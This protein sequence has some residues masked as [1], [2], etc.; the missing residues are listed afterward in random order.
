MEDFNHH[1]TPPFPQAPEVG[2]H[3]ALRS[4]PV[5]P[6][7]L[8]ENLQYALPLQAGSMAGYR[9]GMRTQTILDSGLNYRL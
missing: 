5:R 9:E 6:Y 1:T 2:T 4:I 8:P 3:L 7:W